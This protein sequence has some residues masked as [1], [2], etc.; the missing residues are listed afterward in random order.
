MELNVKHWFIGVLFDRVNEIDSSFSL[1][2][3]RCWFMWTTVKSWS[4]MII[5]TKKTTTIRLT[6]TFEQRCVD[7]SSSPK[8]YQCW[9]KSNEKQLLSTS[10]CF[11]AFRFEFQRRS[12]SDR[13]VTQFWATTRRCRQNDRLA[14]LVCLSLDRRPI[15]Q[16][17]FSNSESTCL[18]SHSD[19]SRTVAQRENN[20]TSAF[21]FDQ[22]FSFLSTWHQIIKKVLSLKRSK[23]KQTRTTRINKTR[24]SLNTD[25]RRKFPLIFSF[26]YYDLQNKSNAL[27]L[28]RARFYRTMDAENER[29]R[30]RERS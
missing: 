13:R 20:K 5:R 21:C 14:R 4:A 27:F 28:C 29:E 8:H 11:L 15:C 23:K 24:Q 6:K 3:F 1:R 25:K 30:R 10:V 17:V 9:T 22:D 26:V 19:S 18:S 16:L 12:H 2:D 7:V